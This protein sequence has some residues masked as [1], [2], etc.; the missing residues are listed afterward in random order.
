MNELSDLILKDIRVNYKLYFSLSPEAYKFLMH[1]IEDKERYAKK[2]TPQHK[3][4]QEIKEKLI[5]NH[6]R[7]NSDAE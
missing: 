6:R 3:A 7:F 1:S 4:F 5:E 2:D